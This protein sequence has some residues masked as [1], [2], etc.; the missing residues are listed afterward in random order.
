ME[1]LI[2]PAL[3]SPGVIESGSNA[4]A[5]ALELS[6][7]QDA[8]DSLGKSAKK[9]RRV[10][11]S[12]ESE[13]PEA[14][15]SK[16]S[17]VSGV[18]PVLLALQMKKNEARVIA[19]KATSAEEELQAA[20]PHALK[21]KAAAE[22]KARQREFKEKLEEAGIN[23]ERYSRLH[24]TQET[25]DA[26]ERKRQLRGAPEST[27]LGPSIDQYA[28]SFARRS[29]DAKFNKEAYEAQR[30]ALGD[31]FYAEAHQ[32]SVTSSFKPDTDHIDAMAAEL[33]KQADKRSQFH[34]RRTFKE[35][36]DITFINEANRKL[37]QQ[38]DK[39]Y[40]KAT[41]AIKDSLE[42]GTAL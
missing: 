20:G 22:E 15:K 4:R 1:D 39:H 25:V 30:E 8:F 19:K 7:D 42:R 28:S 9:K 5:M 6:F 31:D 32:V 27:S 41:A 23:P 29:R 3:D 10:E 17:E 21:Y 12:V 37:N 13:A 36:K 34:R 14:K 2:K 35:E 38:L 11:A 24:E 33:K 40:G 16:M 26:A 18:D